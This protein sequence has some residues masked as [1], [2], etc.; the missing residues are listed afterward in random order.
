MAFQGEKFAVAHHLLKVSWRESSSGYCLAAKVWVMQ[1]QTLIEKL[2]ILAK[3]ILI[4][5]GIMTG[6]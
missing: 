2:F 5:Y 3:Y 6:S 4:V 1:W